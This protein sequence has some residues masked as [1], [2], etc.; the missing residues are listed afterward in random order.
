MKKININIIDK[1]KL[2]IH[3]DVDQNITMTIVDRKIPVHIYLK[4]SIS[5][6]DG[7]NS[8]KITMT[9]NGK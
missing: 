9:Y 5:N 3:E 6:I 2:W 7:E 1:R 4:N 8:K